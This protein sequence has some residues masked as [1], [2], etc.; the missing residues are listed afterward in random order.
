MRNANA[1]RARTI[2]VKF[3]RFKDR[4]NIINKYRSLKLWE[5]DNIYLNEDY[6][7]KTLRIRKELFKQVKVLRAQGKYAK[8]NYNQLITNQA[9][10][11]L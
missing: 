7:E 8:V 2:V 4:V 3:L 10:N 11:F 1:G 6:S 9:S 5:N